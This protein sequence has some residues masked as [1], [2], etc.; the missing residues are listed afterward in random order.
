MVFVPFCIVEFFPL[1]VM[2]RVPCGIYTGS[3]NISNISY[4]NSP[5]QPFFF[6]PLLPGFLE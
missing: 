4:M 1:V 6:I 3:Y 5:P 2:G